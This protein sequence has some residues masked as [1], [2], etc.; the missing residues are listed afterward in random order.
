MYDFMAGGQSIEEPARFE[1]N[2][3]R[4]SEIRFTTAQEFYNKHALEAE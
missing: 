1:L 3:P 2:S 4:L